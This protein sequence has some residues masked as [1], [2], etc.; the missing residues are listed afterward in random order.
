[1]YQELCSRRECAYWLNKKKKKQKRLKGE[2]DDVGEANFDDG[3]DGRV[4]TEILRN[5]PPRRK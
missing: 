1:M 5:L 3:D 2:E 4:S